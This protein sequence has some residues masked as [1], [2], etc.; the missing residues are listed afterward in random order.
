MP[1][2]TVLA[3]LGSA[4][5]A[6]TARTVW[7]IVAALVLAAV[8]VIGS[9]RLWLPALLRRLPRTPPV[10]EGDDH[11]KLAL[12]ASS[13][14]FWDYDLVQRRLHHMRTD[15]PSPSSSAITMLTRV[16]EVPS[17]HPHDL[18][19]VIQ[20]LRNHLRGQAPL[21]TSEHR[22]DMAGN[23]SWAW[24]RARG[25]VVESDGTGRALRLAGTARDITASRKAEYEHRVASEVMRSMSE[26]V[27]VLDSEYRFITVNPSFSRMTGYDGAE[28]AG[29]P[30]A[31][32]DSRKNAGDSTSR[33]SNRLQHDGRWSG[34]AWKARKDGEEILCR[35]ETNVV[36]DASGQQLMVVLVLNDITE[37]KRVEQEL[38]YLANYDTLTSLPNRSLLSERLSRAV[39]RARRERSRVAVL[40]ID[41]DRFKDIN[42]SLGHATGDRILRAAAARVQQTVGAQHTVARLSGDE[43]TVVLEAIASLAEAERVAE[44]VIQ[45]FT[46]PLSFSEG[47]ELAVS[48]SIG[49]SV[50]PDH[51]QVPTELLKHADTA[52][53]QAKAA[54]RHTWA[55]YSEAM[56]EKTRHRAIL[57]SAL[58]R[59]LERNELR[60][61]YQPRL[62]LH[63]QQIIGTEALLR[64]E[65][66]ELGEISPAQFIPLAEESGLIVDIGIWALRQACQT[67]RDWHNAGLEELSMAVN[68]SSL[69]LQRGD[70]ADVV[71]RVLAETGIDAARLELELTESVLMANP[72]QSSSELR[73]CRALGVSIAIDDFGTG[74]SSLA[75][76]KRLP[77]TTL[78]IDQEFVRDIDHDIED[79]AITSAIIAMARSLSLNVVAEGVETV[80]QMAFLQQRGCDEIQ[81]HYVSRA[82]EPNQCLDFIRAYYPRS[83]LFASI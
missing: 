72:E 74:Y 35:I 41:L 79:E 12:W 13:E 21:F 66:R 71:A 56:D 32:L 5:P 57:A 53:Y 36:P 10:H 18:P 25:R 81:G 59:A 46:Q 29:Q 63:D 82:L 58:R 37:Q 11:L 14:V 7:M 4:Q 52:M 6:S 3:L 55:V 73:A 49:I 34:E 64:W 38:R 20:R 54:G 17:I 43:F 31:L 24:V 9:R 45:A 22:M 44:R 2:F 75:Y 50:Y 62:S 15:E 67:L 28:V 1:T 77:L 48:P 70:L 47:L 19:L 60:V 8:L 27:A 51:A 68:V 39:V 83:D 69:Q 40:F 26:A 16:G 65:S 61:V 42:D 78:K 23:G 80:A 33:L 30:L 76:L